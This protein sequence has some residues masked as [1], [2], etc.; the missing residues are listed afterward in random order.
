MEEVKNELV[1][2]T[3]QERLDKMLTFLDEVVEVKITTLEEYQ[4]A[5]KTI[6]T[7]KKGVK[8]VDEDR[9]EAVKDW[10]QKTKSV[11]SHV[12]VYA[13]KMK[14]GIN[15]ISSAMSDWYREDKRK[16]DLIQ[17]QK[18]AEAEAKRRKA[19]E[20]AEK[21]KAKVEKYANEGKEELAEK[22]A[23]RMDAAYEKADNTVAEV[24]ESTKVDGLSMVSKWKVRK[25][26]DKKKAIEFLLSQPDLEE[27]VSI[28]I[29]GLE[30]I[31]QVAKGKKI[32]PGVSFREEFETRSRG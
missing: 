14:N 4:E 21:E 20:A 19:E 12:K 9:K 29:K 17:K 16:K 13:D 26:D 10:T 30:K 6:A 32:V 18:E 3:L 5:A 2:T 22:A 25:V 28:N 1:P 8:S 15:K 11:N 7:I 24:V 23:A 27:L 31:Q